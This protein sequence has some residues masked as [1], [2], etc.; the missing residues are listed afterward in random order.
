MSDETGSSACM[1]GDPSILEDRGRTHVPRRAHRSDLDRTAHALPRS[2]RRRR[3]TRDTSRKSD[4]QLHSRLHG[5]RMSAQLTV[6]MIVRGAD[7]ASSWYQQVFG[8]VE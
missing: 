8:A 2:L 5:L 4:E 6:H 7:D 1:A 3:P